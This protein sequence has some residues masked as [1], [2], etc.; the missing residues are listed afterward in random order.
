MSHSHHPHHDHRHGHDHGHGHGHGPDPGHGHGGHQVYSLL[1]GTLVDAKPWSRSGSGTPHY[2]LL[3]EASGKHY[4]VAI[5]IASSD[6]HSPDKRVLYLI[7]GVTSNLQPNSADALEGLAPRF[8]DFP[9]DMSGTGI[10]GLDFTADRDAHGEPFVRK[11]DMNPLPIYKPHRPDSGQDAVMLLV[12]S[13]K[14]VPGVYLYLFGHKYGTPADPNSW[15]GTPLSGGMHNIHMNQ[16][17]YTGNHDDENGRQ[18]DGALLLRMPQG[19]W[20]GLYVAFQTQS[21]DNDAQGYPNDD[22]ARR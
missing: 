20:R 22:R 21:W 6:P 13:V 1:K 7:R 8:Y 14:G 11:E 19:P 9:G 16:G 15:P 5:N 2:H 4:D 17:N 3:V 10:A 12:Q 18:N